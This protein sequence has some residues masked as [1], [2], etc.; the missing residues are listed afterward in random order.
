MNESIEERTNND[1]RITK[2]CATASDTPSAG[3]RLVTDFIAASCEDAGG[4]KVTPRTHMIRDTR[5]LPTVE[6]Y[7]LRFLLFLFWCFRT[8]PVAL[9]FWQ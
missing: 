9:H 2:T 7:F 6:A 3:L 4:S 8:L 5:R 1:P